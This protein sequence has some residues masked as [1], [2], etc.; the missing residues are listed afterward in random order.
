MCAVHLG[1][2]LSPHQYGFQAG[3]SCASQLI[4]IFHTWV[5]ALDKGKTSDVVFL[6]FEKAFDSVPRV[7][8]ISKPWQYGICGQSL[9]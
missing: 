5:S 8:L 3:L 4:Q 2:L 7:C 1:T 9:E 6:H